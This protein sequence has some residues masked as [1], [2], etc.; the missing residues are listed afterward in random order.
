MKVFNI[1]LTT[2][3]DV[4]ALDAVQACRL[5]SNLP[6]KIPLECF[7]VSYCYD[8]HEKPMDGHEDVFKPAPIPE[9][10]DEKVQL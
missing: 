4:T 7:H 9:I 8:T 1:T 5:A 6:H 3:V 10:K 2:K